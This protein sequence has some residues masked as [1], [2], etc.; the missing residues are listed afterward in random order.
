MKRYVAFLRGVMPTN[1]KMSE[2]ATRFATAGFSDVK[3]VLGSGNVV[4]SARESSESAVERKAE[5]AMSERLGRTF[6]TI[7][8]AI[9]DLEDL[10]AKDPFAAF[11]LATGSKCMVS[12]MRWNATVLASWPW[13]D[14]TSLPRTSRRS[15]RSCLP[16]LKLGFWTGR[17]IATG[18]WA[19]SPQP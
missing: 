7:A 10:L 17:V 13:W 2:L 5:K 4:F 3:T 6:Y 11:K 19:R 1:A 16:H 12:F 14:G 18:S 8:R 15:L 9:D